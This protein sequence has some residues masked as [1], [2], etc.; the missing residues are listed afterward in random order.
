[1]SWSI[2]WSERFLWW[3]WF[4]L[5]KDAARTEVPW[6]G[7]GRFEIETL[8]S[9]SASLSLFLLHPFLPPLWLDP[10]LWLWAQQ[11]CNP[12]LPCS[13]GLSYLRTSPLCKHSS[14][15]NTASYI[16]VH[17]RLCVCV[18]DE[19]QNRTNTEWWLTSCNSP[20]LWECSSRSFL[21]KA[22]PARSAQASLWHDRHI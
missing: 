12:P 6:G 8:R 21:G 2:E 10:W 11:P 22:L 5:V 1:M 4:I 15:K 9:F 16:R 18:C 17:V 7:P 14:G 13:K 20:W 19:R 3:K